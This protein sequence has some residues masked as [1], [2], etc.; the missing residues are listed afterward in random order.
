M[1]EA[2]IHVRDLSTWFPIRRGVFARV[3][4]HVQAVSGV[5]LA[6]RRGE[7][8]A[9]VGE[10][11]CGKTTLGRTMV[12]LEKPM[13]GS[14]FYL[15][16]DMAPM[17][18]EELRKVRR[19]VQFVFQDPQS[20]LNPRMTVLDLVTEGLVA[21]GLLEGSKEEAAALLLADVGMDESAFHRYPFEFSG[22]QR[23]RIC[24]ARALAL[25]P[26]L[27]ICD[28]PVSSLDVSVQAQ[29][30]N[31]LQELKGKYG[32]SYLFISHDLGVV[33]FLADRVAV[34]YLGRIV[35]EGPT[36][37]VM[38]QPL[39]PY[40]QALLSAVP[41]LGEERKSRIVLAGDVPSPA[42]PPPGCPFHTR[43][44]EVMPQCATVAPALRD[45]QGREVSCHLYP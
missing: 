5:N 41:A 18:D 33:R 27:L 32:L 7:T 1:T 9:L 15:G 43:C 3:A 23:Q 10:S 26:S 6:V 4:G 38:D 11:G 17:T 36:E 35:E 42:R 44:P 28:E 16:Q 13:S 22:G 37:Q 40:T 20:A 24:I 8:L 34:M 12:G 29:V 31:L 21:H 25:R 2:L 14:V 19:D 30:I 39:H 45:I